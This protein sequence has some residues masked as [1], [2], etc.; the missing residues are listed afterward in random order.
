[1]AKRQQKKSSKSS[2]KRKK[3]RVLSLVLLFIFVA[4]VG[5]LFW[6]YSEYDYRYGKVAVKDL[7]LSFGVGATSVDSVAR[8]L[9]QQGV[10]ASSEDFISE[11]RNRGIGQFR[12]GHYRFGSGESYRQMFNTLRFGY[13]TPVRVTF[14]NI[15]TVEQLSGV[16][17]KRLMTDS[18]SFA[19]Y[20]LAKES[21][22]GASFI[23]YFTPN[24]Y[25]FYWTVTPEE[26]YDYMKGQY[27][28]F[29]DSD[30]RRRQL[31]GL[32][33]SAD[34]VVTIASIVDEETNYSPEMRDVAGVYINRLRVGM[35]LQADPTVK[36]A[37]GDFSIRRVLH[38]H[39]SYESPYNTYLHSGLP[40][41]PICSPSVAAIEAT[42]SYSDGG[43]GYYYFCAS[44]A[45]DGTH[46][47]ARNL[48]EHNSNARAYQ[49]E[50]SRRG[51]R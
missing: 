14:N 32:G 43:H 8:V 37:V 2:H 13:Q 6:G 20:F 16:L 33:L 36:F 17:A 18:V 7:S 35:P 46:K 41:G 31:S 12:E 39:L 4:F 10:I 50:L 28:S 51:I 42:L 1:M 27:D 49:R 40:P 15:R 34:E 44:T 29:W 22:V 47:F 11:A 38:R 23:G 19:Q 48:S 26:F 21:E 24:T 30:V 3:R 5:T 45:F 9:E 25:E